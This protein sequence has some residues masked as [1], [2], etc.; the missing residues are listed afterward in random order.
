MAFEGDGC[1]MCRDAELKLQEIV[2]ILNCRKVCESWIL[3]TI[4]QFFALLFAFFHQNIN[5]SIL[6]LNVLLWLLYFF[7]FVMSAQGKLENLQCKNVSQSSYS[8]PIL[9]QVCDCIPYPLPSSFHFPHP[10]IICIYPTCVSFHL[11]P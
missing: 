4:I 3:N 1:S 2:H 11:P 5:K 9:L 6:K 7:I 8:M 10:Y